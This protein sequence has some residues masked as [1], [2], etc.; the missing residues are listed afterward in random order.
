MNAAAIVARR[1]RI[2]HRLSDQLGLPP[3][4][5]RDALDEIRVAALQPPA[6]AE[7]DTPANGNVAAPLAGTPPSADT[8]PPGALPAA[9]DGALGAAGDVAVPEQTGPSEH[10]SK[11]KLLVTA[12]VAGLGI[13]AVVIVLLGSASTKHARHAPVTS[14]TA[15]APTPSTLTAAGPAAITTPAHPKQP[16]HDRPA[17]G[18]YRQRLATLLGGALHA[19]GSVALAGT[20]AH[21]RLTLQ[22]TG[23]IGA[24]NGHYEAWL[25]NSILDSVPLIRLRYGVAN[26]TVALP[27]DYRRY[28]WI[29][30]SFQP[31]GMVNDS[32]ESVMRASLPGSRTLTV[33]SVAAG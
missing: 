21:P 1:E 10:R 7:P 14:S 17:A 6:D 2:V 8:P 13:A 33:T 15:T 11:R 27:R 29:D 18:A 12:A 23:L 22:I 30:I 5:V 26:F 16:G 24:H 19:A 32:G 9:S 31:P 4:Q 28:Q 20:A 25:Y 3:D